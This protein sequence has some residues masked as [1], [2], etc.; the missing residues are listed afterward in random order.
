MT[1]DLVFAAFALLFPWLLDRQWRL[2]CSYRAPRPSERLSAAKLG[3]IA[4]FSMTHAEGLRWSGYL[5]MVALLI[6]INFLRGMTSLLGWSAIVLLGI[7]GL[8]AS[9]LSTWWFVKLK[10]SKGAS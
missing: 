1:Y 7:A 4:A 5:A 3:R 9:V 2:M 8:M 10:Y 6:A